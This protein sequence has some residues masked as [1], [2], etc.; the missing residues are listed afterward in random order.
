MG[1]IWSGLAPHPP[2]IVESVG[3]TRC[4]EVQRTIDSMNQLARDLMS[5][6]PDRL[7]II[8]PHTPR[9]HSGIAGWFGERLRGTLAQ[10]GAPSTCFDLPVDQPWMKT[11]SQAYPRITDLGDELLDHGAMV[12][13]HFAVQAG[14]QGPTAVIGLPWNEGRELDQIGSAVRQA[15]ATGDRTAVLAS[16]DMSHCLKP[17]APCGFDERGKLFDHSFVAKVREQRYHD[18][19]DIDPDLRQAAK[20]DVV[21]SCRIA[22][23]AID[24]QNDNHR[25]LSYEGPFGVGYTVMKF[26]GES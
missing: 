26:Y 16:G 24:Y 4:R 15:S 25:F 20:Q 7:V 17:G 6:N 21:E 2:I 23:E 9:P 11:F 14:W 5:H 22:W 12:P 10:F 19:V 8:S 3:G 13:L 18:A 1:I